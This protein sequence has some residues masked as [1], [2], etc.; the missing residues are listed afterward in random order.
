[1]CTIHNITDTKI[2][3]HYVLYHAIMCI[4]QTKIGEK[5]NTVNV[6]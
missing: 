1:M 5:N 6:R 3:K 2:M 4:E